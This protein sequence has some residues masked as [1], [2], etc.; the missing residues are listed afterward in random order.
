MFRI[1]K[2][3]RTALSLI[4]LIGL[5]LTAVSAHA[6]PG[7][8]AS[9]FAPTSSASTSPLTN[10]AQTSA[11]KD[12]DVDRCLEKK[13][14]VLPK[15]KH[16]THGPDAIPPG[17]DIA[18][19]VP[20]LASVQAN[21]LAAEC[22][23]DGSSGL[24]TQA[25]YARASDVPDR[26]ATY[27]ASFRQWAADADQIYQDSAAE[28]GGSRRIRF[29]HDAS[30]VITIPQVTLSP[31][32][33]DTFDN[34]ISEL[35]A[36]GYN[37]SDRKYMIFVDANVYCGIGTIF[38]DDRAGSINNSNGG[39]SYGRSDSGCW[40][41]PTAAHEHM[42]NLGGVQLSAPHTSGGYHCI[43]EYDLMC[44]SD[45]PYFPTMQYLCASSSHDNRFDCNHDDYFHTSP[46]AATYLATHWNAADSAFLIGGGQPPACP[47]A[48]FE[49]DN[50]VAAARLF[51]PGNTETHA[52][53]LAND[54]DWIVFQGTAG[55]T[56]QLETLNLGGG[57][58]TVL[59]LYQSDG[60]TL[61]L[62]NDDSN[63]SLA[64][65]IT[66]TPTTSG[67]YY[68]KARH[69]SGAGGVTL[70]YDLRISF[71]NPNLTPNPGFELDTNADGTPDGWSANARATRS[72]TVVHGGSFA[73]RHQASDNASYTVFSD[74]IT[75]VT[76][77]ATYS[78]SGWVNIPA[79]SDTFS[80]ELQLRW[81][82]SASNV[83]ST[84]P[85][86]SY[87][88]A[89]GGWVTTSASM[90]AP[91]NATQATIR[92]AVTSLNAT[93]YVDDLL[94]QPTVNRLM[95]PGFELDGNA[96]GT[97]DGWSANARATRS[98][99]VVHGGSFAL[100]HQ[101]SDN[102]SYTVFSD[103]VAPVTAGATYNFSGWVNIP[104]TSDTFSLEL[105]LRWRDSASNVLST[106]PI[107][108]Y[109]A[110]TGGWVTT[111]ASVVAPSNAT[112]ATIRLAVTSLNATIYV[113]DLV[114]GP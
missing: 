48:A 54:Q 45:S 34:T 78:F 103:A 26:Y 86:K 90:V 17:V 14:K 9:S 24:R 106:I 19:S 23:G 74:A 10:T 27:L 99:A 79:T 5:L 33:D 83:L 2:S 43:D 71:T 87:T 59:D 22:D 98:S 113:D 40:N 89:T 60:S 63:N 1:C 69:F 32:G 58:D 12:K 65:L 49:A 108:S 61:I 20:P 52:F 7:A 18:K 25:L 30:C 110:A 46:A 105:Q 35:Q 21:A 88:A 93:I 11:K 31:A 73:L 37:R 112:Q 53:C 38:G 28:T 104:A 70:T 111:S 94:F 91:A 62:S 81:R 47:D 56:Y 92:L 57:N 97:P 29:V 84:I 6:A 66:F 4:A 64:S 13:L 109:T 50:S 36:L 102:A 8:Q 16:C 39:P 96:D 77:G 95:N 67:S 51:S 41:G 44:Y 80:L 55:A 72:S 76:A 15:S 100:R 3:L 75:P 42:H 107:K 114:L 68:L 101:A 82:D 85:V